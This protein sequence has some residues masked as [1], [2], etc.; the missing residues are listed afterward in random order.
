[1]S[2]EGK[3]RRRAPDVAKAEILEAARQLFVERPP[4][5]VT[6][7]AIMANTTLARSSFYEYFHSRAALL[8]ELVGPIMTVNRQILERWPV[9]PAEPRAAARN[10]AE[11]LLQAWRSEEGRLLLAL[12]HAS[13]TDDEAAAAYNVFA[14]DSVAQV[15]GKIAL[16]L[17]AGSVSGIDP[18]QTAVA[19]VLLNRAYLGN[20]LYAPGAPPDEVLVSTLVEI[21][22]RVLW[23]GR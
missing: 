17:Q 7:R 5:E 10:V 16:E 3:R 18:Y 1:M 4:Q 8:M 9:Q 11:G 6:V 21:W 23:P 20:R 12:A 13:T 2:D 22:V 15:A 19:F 14:E